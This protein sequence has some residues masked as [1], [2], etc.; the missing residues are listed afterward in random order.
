MT[1]EALLGW[2]RATAPAS[3]VRRAVARRWTLA[4]L[5]GDDG[6]ADILFRHL[7]PGV[8]ELVDQEGLT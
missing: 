2:L 3:A 1:P 4:V 7:W 6:R 8:Y 5:A